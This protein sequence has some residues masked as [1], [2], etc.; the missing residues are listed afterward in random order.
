M[1]LSKTDSLVENLSTI[2]LVPLITLKDSHDAVPLAKALAEADTPVAEITFRSGAAIAGM[3]QI[4]EKMPEIILLAGTVHEV[5]MAKNAISSGCSGIVT[6]A[7]NTKVVK[8]CIENDVSVIPGIATPTD[9]ECVRELGLRYMK[10]FPAVAYG[11]VQTL[12]SLQAPFPDVSF[13]PTGGINLDN[14]IS[15]AKLKNVFAVGGSFPVPN[16]AYEA[17]DWDAVTRHCKKMRMIL[18]SA[19]D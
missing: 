12:T 16:Q 15:F 2:G 17:H 13:L 11:G 6:P 1:K 19:L 4:H 3:E 5:N 14:M 7:L 9:I 18:S 8:W 10:F